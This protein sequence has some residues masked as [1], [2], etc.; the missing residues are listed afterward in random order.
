MNPSRLIAAMACALTLGGCALTLPPAQVPSLV[1]PQWQAPLPH[2]GE[3]A[4]LSQWW[5]SQGDPELVALIEA[6][7]VASPTVAQALARVASARAAQVSAN[8]AL[9]PKLDGTANAVRGVGLSSP[10]LGTT[11]QANL[12]A[13]WELDLVG[14]NRVVNEAARA[15]L[16]GSQAQWHNARVSVA[17]EVAGLYYGLGT[18]ARLLDVARRDALSRMDTARLAEVST[19]AG[20]AAPATSALAQASAAEARS[21]VTSQAAQCDISTKALVELTALPEAEIRKKMALAGTSIAPEVSIS[22]ASVPA[23]ALTQRPDVFAAE[24]D[25]VVA[26]AQV[27]SAQAQR[28]PRLTLNG[29]IGT[30]GVRSGGVTSSLD[31]WS[32]G[33]LALS[34]PL[35]DGG[36]G[37][38][39][40]VLAKANYAQAV[41]AYQSKVRQAVREVEE[42]LVNLESTQARQVDVAVSAK[43]YADAL[44]GT[45]ARYGQGLASLV[46]LEDVRRVALAAQS[47]QIALQ[48]ERQRAWVALYRALGGGWESGAA[49]SRPAP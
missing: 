36:Q 43:G 12:Q 46:E 2:Q 6:A 48:L 15:Q 30:A 45:Q 14:A 26:R 10:V 28:Y 49:A 16:D 25:L 34:V 27:G 21:R 4:S 5:R 24:R 33:P 3:V 17:A 37:A 13:S 11:A 47:G 32:F 41:N 1:V 40:V 22:I 23:Q 18:C 8:A 42:A 20:F 31:T 38:A 39:N 19:K 9:L 7:Q 29:A 44:A 35:F